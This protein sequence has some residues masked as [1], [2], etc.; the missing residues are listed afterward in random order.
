M[1]RIESVIA[2]KAFLGVVE[3]IEYGSIS[4]ET[5]FR[6]RYDDGDLQHLT[7]LEVLASLCSISRLEDPTPQHS[8]LQPSAGKIAQSIRPQ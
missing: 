3:G 1:A 7:E 6:I 4:H 5:L 2:G 8:D